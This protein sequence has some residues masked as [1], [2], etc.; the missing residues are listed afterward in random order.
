[1]T[2]FSRSSSVTGC[3]PSFEQ[4]YPHPVAISDDESLYHLDNVALVSVLSDEPSEEIQY[5]TSV[6]RLQPRGTTC[7]VAVM[8]GTGGRSFIIFGDERL[9]IGSRIP[10]RIK[11]WART[12]ALLNELQSRPGR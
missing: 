7:M 2:G 4:L 9:P 5:I 6:L 10:E 11:K 3:S 12:T 1:M 8:R